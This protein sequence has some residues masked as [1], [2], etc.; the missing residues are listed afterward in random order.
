ML[1]FLSGIQSQI[2]ITCAAYQNIEGHASEESNLF[3]TIPPISQWSS[4]LK[5]SLYHEQKAFTKHGDALH[6]KHKEKSVL[7]DL[8]KKYSKYTHAMHTAVLS[9]R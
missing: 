8:V 4:C 7:D 3:L 9:K 6:L 1:N 5:G 2:G